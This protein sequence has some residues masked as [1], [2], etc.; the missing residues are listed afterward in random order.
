MKQSFGITWD[1]KEASLYRIKNA[2][3]MEMAITDYGA[4]VVSLWVADKDGRLRDVVLGYDSVRE[5]ESHWN[6]LGAIVGRNCNRIEGAKIELD[7]VTYDLEK[8]DVGGNN[9]HS[10]FHG[11]N[12]RIWE[13]KEHGENKITFTMNSPHLDQGF[14]GKL[15]MDVTYEVTDDNTMK[16]SYYGVPDKKTII[17][18]TS[19]CYFNLNGQESG[20]VLEQELMI[21]ASHYT[22]LKEKASIPTGEIAAVEGTPFDFRVAKPIG[23]DIHSEFPQVRDCKGYDHN[24]VLDKTKEGQEL[25]ASACAKESGI[26][27]EVY[28]DRMGLQLYTANGMQGMIGKNGVEYP[29]HGA[30]CLEAQY[31]PNAI[32]EPNFASPIVD[33]GEVYESSTSY[34][35]YTV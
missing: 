27:M 24:F 30:F 35:F 2:N 14:P 12:S 4:A 19:H 9:L 11:W 7:G 17:N 28:T 23:Q 15:S 34:H 1:G 21:R 33:A 26:H 8:N 5:Y 16:V 10:G 20:D 6:Y 13:V 22:P 18:M 31:F 3:G 32:N 25:V 29:T